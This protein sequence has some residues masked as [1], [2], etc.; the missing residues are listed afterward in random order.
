VKYSL[1]TTVEPI[2][3]AP[4]NDGALDVDGKVISM[5]EKSHVKDV[6]S[7]R[8]NTTTQARSATQAQLLQGL[9]SA[10]HSL[11]LA[12]SC[13]AD[14]GGIDKADEFPKFSAMFGG[15]RHI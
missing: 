10:G 13:C 5:S 9:C 14:R 7:G 6:H 8:Q 2:K 12:N 15:L 11:F 1:M 3:I 4:R